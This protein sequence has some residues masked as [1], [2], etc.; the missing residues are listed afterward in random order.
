[1][2]RESGG[3][4][5]PG[6]TIPPVPKRDG[7]SILHVDL[8]A[9][10]VS[11]ELLRRPELRGLPVV[12]AGGLGPRGVVNTCSYEARRYGVRSAM[13]ISRARQLCPAAVYLESDYTYYAPASRAFH[14]ILRS[15]SP[16]VEPGGADEAYLDVAGC[17][18]LFGSPADIG[19]A[20]RARIRA[21]IGITASVGAA[22]ARVVAKVASD[23]AKPDGMLVVPPGEE[24]AFLA[25]RP[26]RDLPMIG[27]KTAETLQ[28]LG[29]RTIGDVA[30]LPLPLLEARLGAHAASLQARAL[31]ID[32]APVHAGRE[33]NRSISREH[34]F[35]VD[36]PSRERLRAVMRGQAERIA[37]DLAAQ[38]RA[39]RTVHLKLRFPPFETLTR[40]ATPPRQ[41]ELARD[42]FAGAAEL[43]EVA[44]RANGERPVRLIGVGVSQL[45]ER[46]RQLHLGESIEEDRLA[47]VMSDIR[48]RFG[49]GV[50]RR[51]AELRR[52]NGARARG[53]P[54]P[55]PH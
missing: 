12:V 48:R 16:I 6:R 28:A 32:D 38:G 1:M 14:E 7:P 21:E 31:G 37:A 35:G 23:A 34:T 51:A 18:R 52:H 17:E 26:L 42:I 13:P 4:A 49:E 9:F 27:P 53:E 30:R 36:E 25:P 46:G 15:F 2:T 50:V 55:P 44:W 3:G 43:F 41:L 47:E 19:A 33:A 5:P 20:I 22:T 10:F 24:A 11:M 45:V 29:C 39:A 54:P 8:D 40:S